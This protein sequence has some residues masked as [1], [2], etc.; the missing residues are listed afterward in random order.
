MLVLAG[1]GWAWHGAPISVWARPEKGGGAALGSV[2]AFLVLEAR[3][4]AE[5]RG[6][7]PYARLGTVL[8][9]RSRR[10]PGRRL[11]VAA[12]QFADA[13]Q[14]GGRPVRSAF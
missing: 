11:R 10:E 7:A 14:R 2:G 5:A 1:A 9:G 8:S 3:E 12:G 6:R 4:H 13:A